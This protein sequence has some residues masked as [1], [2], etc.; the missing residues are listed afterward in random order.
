MELDSATVKANEFHERSIN[1]FANLLKLKAELCIGL[2]SRAGR[3]VD[4]NRLI[5]EANKALEKALSDPESH[6]I[7]FKSD[8]EKYR[9][10]I[11]NK[12]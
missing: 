12:K 5:L 8:P 1:K 11:A 3:L 4:A 10:Y 2:S 7:A 9:E 6:V